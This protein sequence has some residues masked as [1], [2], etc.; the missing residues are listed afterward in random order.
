MFWEAIQ[1]HGH[2]WNLLLFKFFWWDVKLIYLVQTVR[3][4]TN[5]GPICDSVVPYHSR[6]CHGRSWSKRNHGK[7]IPW[8]ILTVRH[9]CF[10]YFFSFLWITL[11]EEFRY[12]CGNIKDSV[13]QSL[14][15][16]D[17]FYGRNIL[18]SFIFR[19]TGEFT[20]ILFL[21]S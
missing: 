1:I 20:P 2:L 18:T 17:C 19:H 13:M 21:S 8:F 15:L 4:C 16:N 6:L 12:T 5:Y 11:L 3:L 7:L 14:K 9:L 10:I